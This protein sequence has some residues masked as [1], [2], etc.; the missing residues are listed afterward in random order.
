VQ[1]FRYITGIRQTH[2]AAQR[3]LIPVLAQHHAAKVYTTAPRPPAIPRFT[4]LLK[5]KYSMLKYCMLGLG[6]KG[7]FDVKYD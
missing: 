2:T 7:V 3:Q 5:I 4:Y 1:P 6:K